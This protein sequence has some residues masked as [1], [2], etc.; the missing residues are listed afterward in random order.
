MRLQPRRFSSSKSTIVRSFIAATTLAGTLLVATPA[1]A[2]AEI[3]S[4][5]APPPPRVEHE[6][7]HRDGYAW[8]PGCWE[9]NGRFFRWSSGTWISERPG[10]WIPDHWDQVGSQWHY[11]RGH[12]ER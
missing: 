8:A 1:P 6:P 5:V 12:W 11:V 9:W 4:D 3:V 7:P 2:V 10:H